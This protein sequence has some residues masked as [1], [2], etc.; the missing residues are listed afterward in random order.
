MKNNEIRKI[1]LVNNLFPPYA[2]GGTEAVVES[3]LSQFRKNGIETVLITGRLRGKR[4][5]ERVKIERKENLTVYRFIPHNIYFYTI[6][7][8]KSIFT[9]L[10]WHGL[11]MVNPF[12]R[13]TLT[14]ILRR[15]KPDL[16]HGHNLKGI[17]YTLPRACAKLNIP[18]VHTLHNYQLLHPFG[19]F[20]YY[21]PP[22]YFRPL[23]LSKLYQ[24]I[25]RYQFAPTN[26]VIS[27][28]RYPLEMHEK[29]GFFTKAKKIVLPSGVEMRSVKNL[30]FS[31][32]LPLKLVY[33]G[34]L[35]KI[36]GVQ[37]L[38]QAIKKIPENKVSLDIFGTG[39]LENQV[40]ENILNSKNIRYLGRLDDKNRLL[41]Y[42]VLVFPSICYETQGLIVLEALSRGLPV[43]A[44]DIGGA[45]EIVKN[46]EN[47]LLYPVGNFE[48]M[49]ECI[50][51]LAGDRVKLARLKNNARR[52][53]EGYSLENFTKQLLE[54]YRSII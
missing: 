6:G 16:I 40:K 7:Q 31:D 30:S 33:V 48:K 3:M 44:S 21:Q 34:A 49:I 32:S 42:E 36:K 2:F 17:S 18:Y 12:D 1:C 54:A 27:P 20:L 23:W 9:K 35:E 37:T 26:L 29:V 50:L 28:S 13:R 43:I 52:S 11:D 51:D 5:D 25:N 19:T 46:E 4:G 22:P 10:I 24:A 14:D 15:E 53:V 45:S 38:I 39:T 8:K 41:N 47:G